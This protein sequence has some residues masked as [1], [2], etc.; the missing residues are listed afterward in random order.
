MLPLMKTKGKRE[1]ESETSLM[2]MDWMG[3][4]IPY[5]VNGSTD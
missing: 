4:N 2:T 1:N 5:L 3:W